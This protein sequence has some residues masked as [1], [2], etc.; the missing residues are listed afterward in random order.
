MTERQHKAVHETEHEIH[1]RGDLASRQ[2]VLEM[3][4]VSKSYRAR[5]MS[6]RL[7][8]D[9]FHASSTGRRT[10]SLALHD[11]SLSL[12]AGECLAIIGESG[13]GKTTATRIMLGLLAPTA[14]SVLYQGKPAPMH[15]PAWNR[16]RHESSMIFQNPYSSL[17]P[18]WTVRQSLNEAVSL[19]FGRSL[20]PD[21]VEA[22][23]IQTL[24]TV[25]LDGRIML[26]RYPIDLSGGQA[27]RVAIA[28]AI[29]DEP[30]ILLADEPMSAVDMTARV[31]ILH[32]LQKIRA[33]QGSS[34][35]MMFV[36]HDIGMVQH[37]ADRIVVLKHGRVVEQA[38]CDEL[39]NHPQ[40]PYTMELLKA[41]SL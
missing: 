5:G 30:E 25:G 14:G 36:S 22:R 9:V 20:D 26:D 35:S 40:Q 21:S 31:Q 38:P 37:I 7:L 3:N 24:D 18:R 28:R 23:S 17:D 10:D 16:L 4:H 1:S 19:R 29:I 41:A 11:V 32:T 13:S 33:L 15:S 27:Q 12:K 6:L 39:L 2:P 8:N 34:L